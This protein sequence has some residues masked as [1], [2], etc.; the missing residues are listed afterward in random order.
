MVPWS[1]FNTAETISTIRFGSSAK[2]IKNKPRVNVTKSVKELEDALEMLQKQV[3][4]QG[5]VIETQRRYIE[6]YQA[7]LK[8]HR[9]VDSVASA[10]GLPTDPP[11][12][13]T[14]PTEPTQL[15]PRYIQCSAFSC[16]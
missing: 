6:Q 16:A 14:S 15:S 4:R 9:I 3:M 8:K 7:L 1:R 13:H 11:S 10:G 5:V 12:Q 2:T